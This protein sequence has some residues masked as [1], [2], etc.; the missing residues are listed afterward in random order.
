MSLS[1]SVYLGSPVWAQNLMLSLYGWRLRQLRYGGVHE[2]V[3]TRLR[4]SQWWPPERLQQFQIESLNRLLRHARMNVPL[5]RERGLPN[6]LTALDERWLAIPLLTKRELREAGRK[7]ISSRTPW[8]RLQEVHTGGTTGTPL[9]VY[10]DRGVLQQN[11]A[12]FARFLEWAGVPPRARVAT[13]AGRVVVPPVQR[14]PPFWRLNRASNTMLFS[15]YHISADTVLAYA[16]ALR[17]WAPALIDSYPSSIL[18]IARFVQESGFQG[19]R[20][21][22]VITSSESLSLGARDLIQGAFGCKV[23]DH[24]GAAE[25][26]ALI[27]QCPQGSYHVNPEFGV[28]ELLHNGKPAEEGELGEIVATGFINPVMPLIRYATGDWAMSAGGECSCGRA[29]PMVARVEGRSDDVIVTP[30]GRL[31]GRLDPIFKNVTS[32]LETRIIQDAR[33]HVCVEVVASAGFTLVEEA[34]LL[35]ELALRLGSS[36]RVEVVRKTTLDRTR[37]GKLRSVVNLVSS[38]PSS[39]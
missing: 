1:R 25:M 31:I 12:F 23:L 29:F 36:M 21:A 7:A 11:F 32:L 16:E 37:G 38:S 22:A 9:T 39:D 30:E 33:D 14:R 35:E 26:V 4:E 18:P 34:A 3:L 6:D 27:T 8:W 15:S 13:F 24:Y 28:I 19:I 5:Y 20:P 2:R 17:D 10:C